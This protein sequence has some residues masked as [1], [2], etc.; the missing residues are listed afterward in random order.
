VRGFAGVA[1]AGNAHTIENPPAH[2]GPCEIIVTWP[3]EDLARVSETADAFGVGIDQLH[4]L[5]GVILPVL[6]ILS[7]HANAARA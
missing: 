7:L 6:V 3:D 1:E 4:H 5:G 2:D